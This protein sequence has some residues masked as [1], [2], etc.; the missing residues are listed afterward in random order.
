MTRLRMVV[1]LVA[2]VH[3]LTFCT[4]QASATQIILNATDSGWYRSDGVHNASNDNFI[5]GTLTGL[6][7]HS[8]FTF[9]MSS[10]ASGSTLVSAELRV[11]N[12]DQ[13]GTQRVLSFFDV[14]TSIPLLQASNS[15]AVGV[16][17][18]NDLGSGT[19]LGSNAGPILDNTLTTTVLATGLGY[20][21]SNF[22][23]EIAFG[24]KY[25]GAGPGDNYVY[26][27]SVG[28]EQRQLVLEIVEVP[29][30]A[31]MV[32]ASIGFLGLGAVSYIRRRKLVTA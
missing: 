31:G 3:C 1:A 7:Y 25:M 26:G 2:V 8:Y 20:I 6:T 19:V 10:I 27:F 24:A 14:F 22:G 12:V 15:G 29:V 23:N 32:L 9:D 21:S 17:I 30:P 11:F 13:L 18:H 16:G 4:Q 28:S 5:S